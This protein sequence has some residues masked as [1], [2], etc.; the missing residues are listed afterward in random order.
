[1]YHPKLACFGGE[2][3]EKKE[4]KDRQNKRGEKKKKTDK[5]ILAGV[6]QSLLDLPFSSNIHL[7]NCSS[8]ISIL[9]A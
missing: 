7:C 8:I 9:R 5:K 6:A 4:K 1:M 2:G 3:G